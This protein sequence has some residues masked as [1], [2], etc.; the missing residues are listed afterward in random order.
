MAIPRGRRFHFKENVMY[1]YKWS[2][3]DD[4]D[5]AADSTINWAE[6]QASSSVNDS[7]RAMMA[8]IAKY[9]DDN[10]GSL[11]TGGTST[12]Y[13]LTTNQIY[14]TVAHLHTQELTFI[15]H[16]TS[17]A[18][19]TLN[20]DGLGAMA[21]ATD[22]AGTAVP[23]GGLVAGT[24]YSATFWNPTSSW[25]LTSF[26]AL[27][28]L[29]PIGAGCDYWGS[30]VPNGSFKFADGSALSRTTYAALF[31]IIGTTFGAGDGS[32]TFNLPDKRG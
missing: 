16:V 29:M 2:H 28:Y 18:S 31:A 8:A 11:V 17:G 5:A 4:A 9:R 15:V 7:A 6:G 26:F 20:V 14:D 22:A 10:N 27:P 19:P 3:T 13:T 25:R 21:I 30:T 12:A 1:L 23:A 24:P 32:T